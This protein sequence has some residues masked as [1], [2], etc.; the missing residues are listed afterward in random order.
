MP[1]RKKALYDPYCFIGSSV[2]VSLQITIVAYRKEE[3]VRIIWCLL[4]SYI[5][6]TDKL[7]HIWWSSETYYLNLQQCN[8]LIVAVQTICL[9][10]MWS[11]YQEIAN[12]LCFG[13]IDVGTFIYYII[14]LYYLRCYINCYV[15]YILIDFLALM[16][17]FCYKTIFCGQISKGNAQFFRIFIS[18]KKTGN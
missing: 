8:K 4:I 17:G 11:G 14:A 2:F 7:N 6:T 12:R 5:L 15:W 1:C 16:S 10:R 13:I 3:K 18:D 9:H